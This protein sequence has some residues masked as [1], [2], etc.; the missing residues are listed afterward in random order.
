VP[1]VAGGVVNADT[2]QT[3]IQ[4]GECGGA[5]TLSLSSTNGNNCNIQ[6]NSSLDHVI[7]TA[8]NVLSIIVGVVAV[9]MIIIGGFRYIASG[10]KQESVSGAKN[11]IL[12][13]IIGLIIVALAQ[14][15][16]RFVLNKTT[17]NS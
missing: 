15:I 10:G 14:V 7:T 11:T 16:V 13:A 8:V 2:S 5:D 4:S 1:L 6:G 9:I 3:T 12:Y 17:A